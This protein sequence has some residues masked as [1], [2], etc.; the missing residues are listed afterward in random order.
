MQ[1]PLLT[2]NIGHWECRLAMTPHPRNFT[3]Y[4]TI[5]FCILFVLFFKCHRIDAVHRLFL[6]F[7]VECHLA[8]P[9]M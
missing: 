6:L 8:L 1:I 9:E 3:S 2:M 4:K 7:Y 5:S